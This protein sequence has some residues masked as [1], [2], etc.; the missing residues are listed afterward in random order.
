MEY[1]S[2]IK[3]NLLIFK[4]C[5]IYKNLLI[6]NQAAFFDNVD[7]MIYIFAISSYDQVNIYKFLKSRKN[8]IDII[9][10]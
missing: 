7:L 5:T 4:Y 10:F 3:L 6:K 2:Y 1:I 9:F 8:I